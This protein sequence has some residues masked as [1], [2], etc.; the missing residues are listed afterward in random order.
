[1]RGRQLAQQIRRNM[2]RAVADE[3][4]QRATITSVANRDTTG[5]IEATTI[6]GHTIYIHSASMY[7]LAASDIVYVQK[8]QVGLA[9]G[10]YQIAGF[11]Q[12]AAGGYIPS[13]RPEAIIDVLDDVLMDGSGTHLKDADGIA[14]MQA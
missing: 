4:P 9:R 6:D 10:R 2:D 7:E 5:E 8:L 14:L 13:I 1:M 3:R 11:H 12:T